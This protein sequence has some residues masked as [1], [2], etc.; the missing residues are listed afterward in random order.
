M[1]VGDLVMYVADDRYAQW[2][3]GKIGV[4]ESL[5]TK[6]DGH[7]LGWEDDTSGEYCRVQWVEPVAYYNR[8]TTYSDFAATK[9]E[10]IKCS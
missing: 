7:H 9:F 2:F 8:H 1:K 10:V 3:F 4:V 5:S 6:H